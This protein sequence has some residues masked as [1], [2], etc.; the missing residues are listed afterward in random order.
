MTKLTTRSIRTK[1]LVPVLLLLLISVNVYA[2]FNHPGILISEIE[3]DKMKEIINSSEDS[4]MKKGYNYLLNG[5]G[6]WGSKGVPKQ[7]Y[8]DMNFIPYPA[9]TDYDRKYSFE[10]SGVALK[11]QALMWVVT[12]DSK[13]ADKALEIYRA[14]SDPKLPA[15]DDVNWLHLGLL[16]IHWPDGLDIIK[17]YN[18]GICRLD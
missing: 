8:G 12:G 4:R 5:N 17:H 2:A 3:L 18:R 11:T 9:P 7:K 10:E 15:P 13:H 14:W 6:P 1:F 16:G